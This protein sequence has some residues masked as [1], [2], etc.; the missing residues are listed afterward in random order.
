MTEHL[1]VILRTVAWLAHK[2]WRGGFGSLRIHHPPMNTATDIRTSVLQPR[3]MA[4]LRKSLPSGSDSS[5]DPQEPHFP[6]RYQQLS[7]PIICQEHFPFKT[8]GAG[9]LAVFDATSLYFPFKL[10]FLMRQ[11]KLWISSNHRQGLCS[12]ILEITVR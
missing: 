9:F 10:Y 1:A 2:Q 6:L 12:W 11:E 7:T 5:A 4:L 8:S 3:Y